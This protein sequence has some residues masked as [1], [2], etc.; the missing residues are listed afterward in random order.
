MK[1]NLIKLVCGL[2]LVSATVTATAQSFLNVNLSDDGTGNTL[3][4]LSWSGD[5]V[6]AQGTTIS[7][8]PTI[9]GWGGV[10][11]VGVNF[12]NGTYS[13]T[14]LLTGFGTML[15]VT[16]G[17]SKSLGAVV[18]S[19][20]MQGSGNALVLWLGTDVFS[21]YLPVSVGDTIQYS[22]GVDSM[23]ISVPFSTFIPGEYQV[24]AE[25]SQYPLS[26]FTETL[27]VGP[28]PEPATLALAGLGGLGL[29][30]FRRKK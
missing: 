26:D 11:I 27:T 13:S 7:G 15:D 29:L 8:P 10:E 20:N 12:I 22:P 23:D 5:I 6:G 18:V 30:I 4:S 17:G 9:G 3:L 24:P 1:T 25:D 28:V 21:D 14:N 16:T 19:D 2:A